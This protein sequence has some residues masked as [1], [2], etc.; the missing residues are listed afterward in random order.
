MAD[1]KPTV[2]C[3]STTGTLPPPP[4]GPPPSNS[5]RQQQKPAAQTKPIITTIDEIAMITPLPPPSAPVLPTAMPIPEEQVTTSQRNDP[6]MSTAHILP[7]TSVPTPPTATSAPTA[8]FLPPKASV[9]Q[10][11]TNPSATVNPSSCLCQTHP[12][13]AQY[14]HN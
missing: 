12:S 4:P 1:K 10:Q 8:N 13:A 3:W 2:Q 11:S 14:Y 9:Q 6:P 7:T 5:H